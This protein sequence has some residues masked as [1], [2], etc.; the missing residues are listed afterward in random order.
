MSDAVE[1]TVRT[2]A[3]YASLAHKLAQ[4]SQGLTPGEASALVLII[5]HAKEHATE[6]SGFEFTEPE[7][8]EVSGFGIMP[9]DMPG[10]SMPQMHTSFGGL[11]QFGGIGGTYMPASFGGGGMY[12]FGS[13]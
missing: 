5:E 7:D 6:V 10:V 12:E 1:T 2:E 13:A 4:F 3:D 8:D 9:T 11:G